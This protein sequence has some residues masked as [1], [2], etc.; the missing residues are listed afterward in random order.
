[1]HVGVGLRVVALDGVEDG[2]GLLRGVGRVEVDEA[3]AVDLPLQ[4]REVL[5]DRDDVE[6]IAGTHRHAS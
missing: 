5:L 4:D 2:S 6:R 1:V 3:A